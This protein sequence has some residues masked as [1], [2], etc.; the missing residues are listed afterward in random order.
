MLGIP[1]PWSASNCSCS[2]SENSF[3][4]IVT[5]DKG[6]IF[7]SSSK[8]GFSRHC[9]LNLL[10]PREDIG[11]NL[12][13]YLLFSELDHCHLNLFPPREYTCLNLIASSFTFLLSSKSRYSNTLTTS[14]NQSKASSCSSSPII[15]KDY[16]LIEDLDQVQ[17]IYIRNISGRPMPTIF[18]KILI[19]MWL[20]KSF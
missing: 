12:I 10:P 5:N 4:T 11:S 3:R 16:H 17:L 20:L 1:W 2:N 14:L 15:K 8:H 18:V 6:L 19:H 9:H 7:A 13:A